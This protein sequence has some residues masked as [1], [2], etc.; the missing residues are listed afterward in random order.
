LKTYAALDRVLPQLGDDLVVEG[1]RVGEQ[2]GVVLYGQADE[3]VVGHQALV[4]AQQLR[5]AVEL[6]QQPGCDL[7]GLDIASEGARECRAH[8]ALDL[9]LDVADESHERLLPFVSL[10]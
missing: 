2:P 7:D 3:E 4:A 8:G 1:A 6:P 10:A 5:L 9:L